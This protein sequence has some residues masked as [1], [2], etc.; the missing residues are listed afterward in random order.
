MINGSAMLGVW[1]MAQGSS[2]DFRQLGRNFG[3]V[4]WAVIGI[5]LLMSIWSFGVMLDRGLMYAAARKHSRL[6]VRQVAGALR[7]GKLDEAMLIAER[8]KKSHIAKVTAT[9][10]AEFQQASPRMSQEKV[11]ESA[12]RSLDRSVAIVHAEF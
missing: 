8:N 6:F 2:F 3:P 4:G 7:E 10:L 11:I 9:G 12:R 1:M 5:L